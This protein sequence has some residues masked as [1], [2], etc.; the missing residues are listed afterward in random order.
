M[1]RGTAFITAAVLTIVTVA[2]A[3]AMGYRFDPADPR[4]VYMTGMIGNQEA[5]RFEAIM[6]E[7][8]ATSIIVITSIGGF[9][10]QAF[11]I[12]RDIA[13]GAFTVAVEG[14]CGSACVMILAAGE[15]KFVVNGAKIGVHRAIDGSVNAETDDT[16]RDTQIMANLLAAHGMPESAKAEMLATPPNEI[17]NLTDE[18]LAEWNIKPL[19]IASIQA[20]AGILPQSVVGAAAG[21]GGQGVS[22]PG[23]HF[24]NQPER[25]R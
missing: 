10:Q 11:M 14:N 24:N 4:V 3:T 13:N 9:T 21:Q 23:Q 16:R 19:R 12:A 5:A 15:T 7:H 20:A 17:Y 25:T 6:K 22:M 8:P 18:E 2:P 1:N